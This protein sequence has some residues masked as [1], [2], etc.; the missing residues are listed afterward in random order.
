MA[1]VASTARAVQQHWLS[2][3]LRV[4]QVGRSELASLSRSISDGLP[5]EYDEFLRIAGLPDNEDAAGFRFWLPTEVTPTNQ[6]LHNAGYEISFSDPSM[7][8]AD[9]MQ[10]SWWY[11]LWV[12]GTF[13]GQ[14][15]LVLGRE[16]HLNPVPTFATF[17][18]FLQAYLADDPQLYPPAPNSQ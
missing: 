13:R 8:I 7:I 2:H 9:Y 10:E 12:G 3:G 16:D 17:G 5:E 18:E 4:F 15:S 1:E 6:V 14:V 11:C